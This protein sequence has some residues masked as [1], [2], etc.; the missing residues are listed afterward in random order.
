MS[1]INKNSPRVYIFDIET[2]QHEIVG[3]FPGMTFAPR[4]SPNGKK[5]IM[6]YSR[7]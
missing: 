3:E 5:I 1:Y 2:G 4:F 7:S 6:S